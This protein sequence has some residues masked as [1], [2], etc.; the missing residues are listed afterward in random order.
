MKQSKYIRE[1]GPYVTVQENKLN[2][3]KRVAELITLFSRC[4]QAKE[5]RNCFVCKLSKGKFKA[6]PF[7]DEHDEYLGY[8]NIVD[9]Y[10]VDKLLP[11]DVI[12]ELSGKGIKFSNSIPR[13]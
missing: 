13:N 5:V 10:K 1:C 4:R 12:N 11:I 8:I 9:M 7:K 6:C 3:T 2:N